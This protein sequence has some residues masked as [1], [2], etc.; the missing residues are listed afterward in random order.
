MTERHFIARVFLIAAA[1][2][3]LASAALWWLL[4]IRMQVPPYVV[5]PVLALGYGLFCLLRRPR[6][7][8][9]ADRVEP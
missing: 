2:L 6:V 5:S 4:P 1:V 8:G 3:A 7:P 9:G